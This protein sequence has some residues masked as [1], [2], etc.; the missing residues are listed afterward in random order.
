MRR[1]VAPFM[2]VALALFG[3]MAATG[4]RTTAQ[5][6]TPAAEDAGMTMEGIGFEPLAFGVAETLPA[7]PAEL[8]LFRLRL[9][10]GASFPFDPNDPSTGMAY[11]EEGTLTFT[12]T[13][14]PMTI[15]RASEGEAPFPGEIEEVPAG[16]DFTLSAGES[17]VFPSHVEG[18]GRNEGSEPATVLVAN[19]APAMGQV[20]EDEAAAEATPAA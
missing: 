19:V 15:L 8:Q 17:A 1:M 6:A 11:V 12:V 18:S 5:E 7:A 4:V 16:T 13:S 10:P 14:S 3:L 2:V 20:T 9:E